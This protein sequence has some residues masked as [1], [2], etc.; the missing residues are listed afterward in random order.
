MGPEGR[1]L[2][3]WS[4]A[5]A[6]GT[7][8]VFVQTFEPQH[9]PL[10][11]PTHLLSAPSAP[12]LSVAA[13]QNGEFVALAQIATQLTAIRLGPEADPRGE[14]FA[15]DSERSLQLISAAATEDGVWASSRKT[16]PQANRSPEPCWQT[17]SRRKRC[18]DSATEDSTF[19]TEL[20]AFGAGERGLG[21]ALG[22]YL[23]T[24][25]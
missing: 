8:D 9:V 25:G 19:P 3:L 18:A 20:D 11:A 12:E 23:G 21:K 7:T 13:L 16:K 5:G 24:A 22:E 17:I 6:G 14:A 15:I 1:Y 4:A 10:A 2:L